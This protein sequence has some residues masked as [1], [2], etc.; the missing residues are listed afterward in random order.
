MND[1]FYLPSLL[2]KY[3]LTISRHLSNSQLRQCINMSA[4]DRKELLRHNIAFL[5]E[6]ILFSTESVNQMIVQAV[7]LAG[8]SQRNSSTIDSYLSRSK[9]QKMQQCVVVLQLQ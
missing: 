5:K 2:A 8:R 1:S 7:K 9:L 6:S 4:L 3:N